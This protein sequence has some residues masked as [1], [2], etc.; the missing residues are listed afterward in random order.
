MPTDLSAVDP[1]VT[2]TLATLTAAF[3]GSRAH[4]ANADG[5]LA[6]LTTK[7]NTLL[8]ELVAAGVLAAS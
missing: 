3:T 1:S 4:I 5:T 6:D 7:F 8:T 2:A